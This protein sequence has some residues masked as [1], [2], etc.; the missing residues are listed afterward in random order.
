MSLPAATAGELR[1]VRGPSAFGADATRFWDLLKLISVTEFRSQYAETTLGFL[2]TLVRP[3][4]FFG[5][6]FL[7]LREVLRVGSG[8]PDYGPILVLNLIL[9]TY[10]QEGT[11]RAVRSI[12]ARE[13]FVRKMQFPRIIIPLSIT[14]SAGVSMLLNLLAVLP[15]LLLFGVEPRASWLLF[16]LILLALLALTTAVALILSVL[17]VRFADTAQAWSLASRLLFYASPVL[18][19]IEFVPPS[20]REIIAASPIALLLEQTRVWIVD[21]SATGAIDAAGVW[22]GL[23]VPLTLL[24]LICGF[25]VWLF[26]RQAP[27]LGELI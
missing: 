9:F 11:M 23:V 8:T 13:A 3:L 25:S 20:F 22:V 16:P 1:E 12:A 19:V 18:F 5:V 4:I 27:R 6:I 15:L 21:P 24:I 7:V 26:N 14:L 17:F 10:F 2:W